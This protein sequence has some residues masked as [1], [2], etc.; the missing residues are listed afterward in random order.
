MIIGTSRAAQS[1]DPKYLSWKAYNFAFTIKHSPFDF[2][3]LQLIKKYHPI[4]SRKKLVHIIAVDPWSLMSFQGDKYENKNGSFSSYMLK[5]NYFETRVIYPLKFLNIRNEI[6]QFEIFTKKEHVNSFGR[7]V[8]PINENDLKITYQENLK[9]K[10]SG[11]KK[12]EVYRKGRVSTLRIRN[13]KRIISYLQKDGK[14][15]LIRLPVVE[16]MLNMEEEIFPYFDEEIGEISDNYKLKYI[17][18]MGLNKKLRYLDGN[19]IW[20]RDVKFISNCIKDSV[21]DN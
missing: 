20:N 19:H 10:I 17:N 12:T 21:L 14:V 16:E 3:Y 1:I 13:L 5:L 4:N 9:R 6:L 8:I 15:Y 18:L 2:S 11:Y 7:F